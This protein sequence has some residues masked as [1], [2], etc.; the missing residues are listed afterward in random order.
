MNLCN[1]CESE[2]K[3]VNGV[4]VCEEGHVQT[5]TQEVTEYNNVMPTRSNALVRSARV[6]KRNDSTQISSL[7]DSY[8]KILIF[9]FVY[10][11][12]TPF[13]GL[14]SDLFFNLFVSLLKYEKNEVKNSDLF[15]RETLIL[16]VYFAKKH[17]LEEK[18]EL[19]FFNEYYQ[20]MLESPIFNISFKM[21]SI[22]NN[23]KVSE[24]FQNKR[25]GT[26]YIYR[27]LH[28]LNKLE[29]EDLNDQQR[30]AFDAIY[31][32]TRIDM[33]IYLKYLKSI[34]KLFEYK[35][36]SR[37]VFYFRKFV[38]FTDVVIKIYFPDLLVCIFLNEYFNLFDIKLNNKKILKNFVKKLYNSKKSF[39]FVRKEKKLFLNKKEYIKEVFK[40]NKHLIND[41]T[42]LVCFFYNI[43]KEI[44]YELVD[45]FMLS[46]FFI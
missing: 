45:Q 21:T 27:Y 40:E 20:F 28:T 44:Y 16:L 38:Y 26:K 6:I 7:H 34:L 46:E 25:R 10:R 37:L 31:N 1:L 36:E 5:Y 15:E 41:L 12:I 33:R 9:Y 22:F 43:S 39:I 30:L 3:C 14:K 24:I 13:F 19:I 4:F 8:K 35:K 23:L 11:Q 42:E 2:I 18:N 17:E 29:K 32:L